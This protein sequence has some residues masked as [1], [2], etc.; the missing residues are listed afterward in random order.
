MPTPSLAARPAAPSYGLALHHG[1]PLK[2]VR[3]APWKT[4]LTG[5]PGTVDDPDEGP[6]TS[7]T[8]ARKDF[9]TPPVHV[10]LDQCF[11]FVS[12]QRPMPLMQSPK[13]TETVTT[14][15]ATATATS[16]S[17]GLVLQVGRG[18]RV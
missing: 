18:R 2:Q 6:D 12:A 10:S 5:G 3:L 4:P 17:L 14:E 16:P 7:S 11:T 15:T 13:T 8:Q 9:P 1:V